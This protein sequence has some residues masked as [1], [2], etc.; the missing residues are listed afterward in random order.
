M[1]GILEEVRFFIDYFSDK[2]VYNGNLK[3]QGASAVSGE[4]ETW[5]DILTIGVEIHE[6]W[7]YYKLQDDDV[8]GSD[9]ELPKYRYYRLYNAQDDGCDKIGEVNFIGTIGF[10]SE[11]ETHSCGVTIEGDDFSEQDLSTL[12][13]ASVTYEIA[14]TPYLTNIS[15]R[16]GTVSGGDTV[17]FTGENFSAD[18][19]DYTILIDGQECVA[20]SASTTE[21]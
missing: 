4:T 15:P 5:N 1:V 7:N 16:Y 2:S 19:A 17:T 9:Y 13:G 8:F 6:G 18:P 21:V 12:G 20:Q 11:E 14:M 3:L 10:D